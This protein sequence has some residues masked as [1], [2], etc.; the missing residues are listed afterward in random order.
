MEEEAAGISLR[1]ILQRVSFTLSLSPYNLLTP[2]I[3]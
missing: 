3:A 1:L 2:K